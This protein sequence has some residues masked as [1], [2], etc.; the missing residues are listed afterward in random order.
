MREVSQGNPLVFKKLITEFKRRIKES[1]LNLDSRD[2]LIKNLSVSDRADMI[3]DN[4]SLLQEFYR[5]GLI[6]KSV[7]IELK[8][9]GF[10]E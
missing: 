3:M 6:S 9:R 2:K 8:A 5:K 4:P 10:K 1:R 7:L